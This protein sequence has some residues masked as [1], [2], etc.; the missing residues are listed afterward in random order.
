M[1]L[2]E[3]GYR[4]KEVIKNSFSQM[5]LTEVKPEISFSTTP[6]TWYSDEDDA[7]EFA[8]FVKDKNLC[9]EAKACRLLDHKFSF[10]SFNNKFIGDPINWHQDYLN[11]KEAPLA[12]GKKIDYRNSANVGNIKYIWEYFL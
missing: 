5:F 11:N 2:L 4:V 10:F 9:S 6:A 12:Y 8:A 1:S 3:F 7:E